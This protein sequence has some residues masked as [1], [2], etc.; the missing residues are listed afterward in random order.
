VHTQ[1]LSAMCMEPDPRSRI[2]A[3]STQQ[4]ASLAH[5]S[6]PRFECRIPSCC[7]FLPDRQSMG[8]CTP[9]ASRASP[10]PARRDLPS[11]WVL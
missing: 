5:C 10:S 9:F 2:K 6:H 1:D 4:A 8:G 3:L 7:C 11:L